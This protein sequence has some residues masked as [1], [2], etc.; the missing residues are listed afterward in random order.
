MGCGSKSDTGNNKDHWNHFQ[1]TQAIPKQHNRKA[2]NYVT[3][4]KK[5][6]IVHCTHTKESANV[7][8]QNI[9]HA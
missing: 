2:R 5:S 1:I 8:V 6:D 7:N 9:F 3:T 4:K